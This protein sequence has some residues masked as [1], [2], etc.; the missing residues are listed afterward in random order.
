[1][2]TLAAVE[3]RRVALQDELDA[4]KTQKERN[5]LGQ[6]ATPTLLASDML[7]YARAGA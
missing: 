2:D 1:M 6:F 5:R 4:R 7:A 3:A